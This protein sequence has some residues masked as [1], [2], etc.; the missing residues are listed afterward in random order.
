[1]SV[2]YEVVS[3]ANPQNRDDIKYYPKILHKG[4]IDRDVIEDAIVRETSL[5]RGD[6]RSMLTTFRDIIHDHLSQGFKVRLED[7][8]LLYLRTKS[9]GDVA[10]ADVNAKNIERVSIGFK[11]DGKLMEMVSKI[12][13]EKS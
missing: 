3:R 1:M 10:A 4:I 11:G 9:N 6:V 7:I 8:G 13:F 12:K 2:E 5:S